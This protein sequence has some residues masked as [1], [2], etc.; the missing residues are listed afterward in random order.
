MITYKFKELIGH[1]CTK[2]ENIGDET[3][4]FTR[5]D[6]EVFEFY[7]NY[8][9]CELV[10]IEDICGELKDLENSPIFVAECNSN[11]E[12]MDDEKEKCYES[13]TWTFYKFATNNS[14]I[15]LEAIV[16]FYS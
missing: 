6:G 15:V 8:D 14:K 3:L 11:H 4:R 13:F 16:I 12:P 5:E 2:V 10:R 1:I 7:H 9:C